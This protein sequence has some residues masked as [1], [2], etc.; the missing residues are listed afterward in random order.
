MEL[1]GRLDTDLKMSRIPLQQGLPNS[2]YDERGLRL[3]RAGLEL[4]KKV[5]LSTD[6]L[7]LGTPRTLHFHLCLRTEIKCLPEVLGSKLA[8]Q[9]L[10]LWAQVARHPG[11]IGR[12]HSPYHS[13]DY[14]N[15]QLVHFASICAK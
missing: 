10:A 15:T 2:L 13:A 7:Y 12:I 1:K 11:Q 9:Y 4:D 3:L 6:A 5:P 8:L 14:I